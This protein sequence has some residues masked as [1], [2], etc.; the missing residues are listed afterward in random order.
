MEE[1]CRETVSSRVL[2]KLS[3]LSVRSHEFANAMDG[4]LQPICN[5]EPSSGP[6]E[7]AEEESYPEL[8]ALM[9][10]HIQSIENALDQAESTLKRCE[11]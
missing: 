3:K 5:P 9:M 8:F 6:E 4:R 7:E 10:K 2:E 1:K 11:I